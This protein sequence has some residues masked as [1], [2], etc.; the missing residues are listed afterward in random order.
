MLYV[1][2]LGVAAD[3]AAAYRWFALAARQGDQEAAVRRDEMGKELSPADRGAA[4]LAIASWTPVPADTL[5]NDGPPLPQQ[6]TGVAAA[7]TR[8]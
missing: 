6:W 5:A 2:G 7:A 1:R 8:S 3:P 4:D